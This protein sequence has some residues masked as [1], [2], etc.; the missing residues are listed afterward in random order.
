[1]KYYIIKVENAAKETHQMKFYS[2]TKA[3]EKFWCQSN[4][5]NSRK[6]KATLD[7]TNYCLKP[8]LCAKHLIG[9]AV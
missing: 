8:M 1:M 3:K 9:C 4:L 6:A 7:L 5:L 2:I